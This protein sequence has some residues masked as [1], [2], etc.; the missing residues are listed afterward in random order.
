MEKVNLSEMRKFFEALLSGT[1]DIRIKKGAK[2]KLPKEKVAKE[3][4]AKKKVAKK[5]IAKKKVAKRRV[6]KKGKVAPKLKARGKRKAAMKTRKTKRKVGRKAMSPLARQKAIAKARRIKIREAKRNL[7]AS[8]EVF[9]FLLGKNDGAKLSV[10][11][12][13]FGSRRTVLKPMLAK[14]VAKKD[15]INDKEVYYLKRRIRKGGAAVREKL[16]PVKAEAVVGY[17]KENPGATM[18]QMTNGLQLNSYQRLIKVL[19]LLKKDKKVTVDGKKYN[20]ANL[21]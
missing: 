12:K 17:L 3:R 11:A 2:K 4:V 15:L 20:L 18:T 16:P 10:L 13:Y 14:L 5:K 7:P 9:E 21:E 6:V 19:N 8:R 1:L